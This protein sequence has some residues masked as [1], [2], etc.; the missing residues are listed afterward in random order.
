ML[1]ALETI[2]SGEV[3]LLHGCC[4]NPCG[5]DLWPGA[6]DAIAA[7]MSRRGLIPLVDLAYQGFGHGL[8]EDAAGVRLLALQLPELLVAFSCS[9]NFGLYSERTGCTLVVAETAKKAALAGEHMALVARPLYSMPPDHGSAIVR[10]ILEDER[11]A[12]SWRSELETMRLSIVSKRR[13]FP[14]RSAPRRGQRISTISS[15]ARGCSR[16]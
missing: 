7:I 2:P 5:A 11:L 12:A 1:S 10:T 4:H 13:S 6:W 16:S 8:D 3:V 9:K 14:L 15:T